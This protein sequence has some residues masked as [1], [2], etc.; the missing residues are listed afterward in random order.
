[1][2]IKKNE[3][4]MN[5]LVA[6]IISSAIRVKN[7]SMMRTLRW[8]NSG[9]FCFD[10]CAALRCGI[11]PHQHGR[12]AG[13]RESHDGYARAAVCES[14]R[15]PQGGHAERKNHRLTDQP[16]YA[17]I[18]AAVASDHFAHHQR[19]Q[20]ADLNREALKKREFARGGH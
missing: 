19:M 7:T 16:Q 12:V 1:M 9:L 13:D 15:A 4:T 14:R 17:Q 6:P 2:K 3:R 8:N 20:H 18:V 11:S 10:A 5:E